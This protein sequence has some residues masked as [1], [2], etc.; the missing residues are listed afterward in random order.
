MFL[1]HSFPSLPFGLCC[2]A[3]IFCC[4]L[5]PPLGGCWFL[6]LPWWA[7]LLG[8]FLSFFVVLLCSLVWVVLFSPFP[9]WVALL[10]PPPSVG[11]VGVVL[12]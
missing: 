5:R 3:S 2:M 6:H 9:V 8:M 12:A 10:A 11:L 7:L 1:L 4:L